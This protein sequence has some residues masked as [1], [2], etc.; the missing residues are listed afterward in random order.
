[1]GGRPQRMP[2]ITLI[3]KHFSRKTTAASSSAQSSASVMPVVPNVQHL[4]RFYKHATVVLHPDNESL[5]KLLPTEDVN[6]E[7]LSMSHGPYW[8][9]ALD[10]RVIK[11]M[12]KDTMPIPSRALA[13]AIAEEWE[14]QKEKIDLKTLHL[15]HMLARAIRATHDPSLAVHMQHE[16]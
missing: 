16:I 5:P 3:A 4:K 13:V 14:S 1:M 6:F 11:T 10:G 7:N 15:N 9:V 12:Y 2:L 8:A